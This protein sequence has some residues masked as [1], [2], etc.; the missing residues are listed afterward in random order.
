MLKETI[1]YE[2]VPDVNIWECENCK[3]EF[4]FNSDEDGPFEYY[5]R[6]CPNCGLYVK[7]TVGLHF[8]EQTNKTI[9]IETNNYLPKDEV[10]YGMRET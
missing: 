6:Y 5:F 1:F 7:K 9:T 10:I 3:K 8:D 2:I 4:P